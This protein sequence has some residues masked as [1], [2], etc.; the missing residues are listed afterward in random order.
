SP[1]N[2]HHKPNF[3]WD[4]INYNSISRYSWRFPI[5]YCV[6]FSYYEDNVTK[7]INEFESNTCISFEKVQSCQNLKEGI[8]FRIKV[9]YQFGCSYDGTTKD[10]KIHKVYITESCTKNSVLLIKLIFQALG[11]VYH[12]YHNNRDSYV[13]LHNETAVI[14]KYPYFPDES[15]DYRVLNVSYDYGSIMHSP[16]K[17]GFEKNYKFL[18]ANRRNLSYYYEKMMGQYYKVTFTDWKIINKFYCN[19][20][21]KV[22]STTCK[23][24]GYPHPRNCTSCICPDGFTGDNCKQISNKVIV[25]NATENQKSLFHE[26]KNNVTFKIKAQ[27]DHIILLSVIEMETKDQIPC[28]YGSGIEIKH[29][30]YKGVTGLCLCGFNRNIEIFTD[31]NEALIRYVG[32]SRSDFFYLEYIAVSC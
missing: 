1:P 6:D 22:N 30:K 25:H 4:A 29:L 23:N 24:D 10:K 28:Y 21:C 17:I 9:L 8:S 2:T 15:I 3:N 12:E 11:I 20:F 27:N 5:K 19:D 7:A 13:T 18:S 14:F 16:S 32:R 26:G 31:G